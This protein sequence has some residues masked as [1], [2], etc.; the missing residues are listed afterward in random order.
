M[1]S[2]ILSSEEVVILNPCPWVMSA[3]NVD[4]IFTAVKSAMSHDFEPACPDPM[5]VR[6]ADLSSKYSSTD[7]SPVPAAL[8]FAS[9]HAMPPLPPDGKRE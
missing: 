7:R 1:C 5:T 9:C 3:R 8:A 2:I 6:S 4:P